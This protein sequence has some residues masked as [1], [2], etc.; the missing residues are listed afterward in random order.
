MNDGRK[1]ASPIDA[2]K[3]N[4]GRKEASPID[5]NGVSQAASIGFGYQ[6][7][8]QEHQNY[9]QLSQQLPQNYMHAA[10]TLHQATPQN[11][12]EAALHVA[13]QVG[14]GYQY[15]SHPQQQQGFPPAN[16][17]QCGVDH[18]AKRAASHNSEEST[19]SFFSH[20]LWN[21]AETQRTDHENGVPIANQDDLLVELPGQN[22]L[23]TAPAGNQ[24]GDFSPDDFNNFLQAV[25][26]LN[27]NSASE[28]K[29]PAQHS[30]VT[31]KPSTLVP[32][33]QWVLN[34][35]QDNSAGLDQEKLVLMR[36]VTMAYA[37]GR[38]LQHVK[39]SV[40]SYSQ[41]ELLRLCSVDNFAVH[42]S[43]DST[44]EFEAV[45]IDMVIPEISM[46]ITSHTETNENEKWARN[47]ETVITKNSPFCC[48]K[49]AAQDEIGDDSSLC[50]SLGVLLHCTFSGED[51]SSGDG[52]Y[53]DNLMMA[54]ASHNNSRIGVNDDQS[55]HPA[56]LICIPFQHENDFSSS[57]SLSSHNNHTFSGPNTRS[58]TKHLPSLQSLGCPSNI[59]QL[60]NNLLDCECEVGLFR[61]EDS[62]PSLS[63]A[64]DDISLLLRE[65]CTFLFQ[66]NAPALNTTSDKLYGRAFE[67]ASL[68]D[69]FCRVAASGQSEAFVVGGFSG[70]VV[71][72]LLVVRIV[73]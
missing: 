38:L 33:R 50:Y 12:H 66:S 65:P 73:C 2:A 6:Y 40:S 24:D 34:Q 45:Q 16:R 46:K 11:S 21:E 47:V 28:L 18:V 48:A 62:Y 72:I 42:M 68:S 51:I 70:Y 32:L 13:N 7:Y 55:S 53:G 26:T 58:T 10:Q 69:A 56:K 52:N 49:S 17:G 22:N 29:L 67:A 9:M 71:P 25:A 4:D 15:H 64:V 14:V 31:A 30:S 3:M 5:E 37:I 59:S 27:D 61:P 1:E 44:N 60:V 35:S 23:V 20:P 39:D 8:L 41:A 54:A 57:I 63:I 36:K 43:A 19:D